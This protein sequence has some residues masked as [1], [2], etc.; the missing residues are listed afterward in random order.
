MYHKVQSYFHVYA[1][2]KTLVAV[3]SVHGV[4]S[5]NPTTPCSHKSRISSKRSSARNA[6]ILST[7]ITH[8]VVARRRLTPT[9]T[10]Q[11]A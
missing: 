5:N 3:Q 8:I 6:T 4:D 10:K 7:T 1:R 11:I 2:H 9:Q